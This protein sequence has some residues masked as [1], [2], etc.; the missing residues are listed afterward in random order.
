[1]SVYC[2]RDTG[3]KFSGFCLHGL[4]LLKT[5]YLIKAVFYHLFQ[6]VYVMAMLM[7]R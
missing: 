6:E 1:M 2:R 4:Q 5:S 7:K 3:E